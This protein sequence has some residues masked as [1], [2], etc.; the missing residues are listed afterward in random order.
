MKVSKLLLAGILSCAVLMTGCQKADE[1]NATTEPESNAAVSEEN[2]TANESSADEKET[3]LRVMSFNMKQKEGIDPKKQ[4]EWV[5][6]FKPDIVATQ[7]VDNA[8]RRS[9]YDVTALFQEGGAF[10]ESFFSK[11]MPFQG[12]DYGL[13]MFSNYE[14]LEKETIPIYSDEY[15]GDEAVREEQKKLFDEMDSADP[16]T[17]AAYDEF[18]Q[19]LEAEGKRGIEPNI[20]QKIVIE[21]EGKRVSVYGVHLS[22]E[23]VEVRDK[24]RE[25]L[26]E[27]L[28]ADE[29]EY[30]IVVGDF[31]SD[32]GTCEMNYFVENYNVANGK[33]GIWH[34]T[35]PI[36]DDPVMKTYSIDNI[37]TTKNI[38]IKN[39]VYEKTDLTD[40][41]MIY[42]DLILN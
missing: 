10:K 21:F 16:Q 42:A 13:A 9:P 23:L 32:Q 2:T 24:Q 1:G 22:Y 17:S 15:M 29:N 38:E 5:A 18:C 36:G 41:T 28:N 4:A 26:A 33:D 27:I 37:V 6:S 25:Q 19:K 7:E 30:Q 20:I 31:N 12:G 11:Q 34:D 3:V 8:T 40:H 35:F 39:V 14:I